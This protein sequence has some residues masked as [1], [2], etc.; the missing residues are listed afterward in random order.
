MRAAS[1]HIR[2]VARYLIWQLPEQPFPSDHPSETRR[3]PADIR[4]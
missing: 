2:N 4:G 3:T 1:R